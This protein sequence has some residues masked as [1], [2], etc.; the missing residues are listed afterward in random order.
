MD[1]FNFLNDLSKKLSDALPQSLQTLKKDIE[2][3]FHAV[4]Q[5]AFT[6][7]DLVTREEFDAQTK[8]LARSRKKIAELEEKI[9]DLEKRAEEKHHGH[10]S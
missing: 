2:K 4:L 7:L 5:N 9:K 6:K 10:R 1:K 3:N 8:V